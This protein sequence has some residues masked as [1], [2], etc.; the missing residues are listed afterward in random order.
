LVEATANLG[1]RNANLAD[2]TFSY[3]FLGII[4][5][6]EGLEP[7]CRMKVAEGNGRYFAVICIGM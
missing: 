6:N 3:M 2:V 1:F 7:K 5:S 4:V